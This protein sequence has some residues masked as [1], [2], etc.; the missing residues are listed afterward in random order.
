M[1]DDKIIYIGEALKT[2]RK[3]R[4]LSQEEV[5]LGSE[6][7]RSYI[8]EMERNLKSPSLT[9]IVKLSIVLEVTP[10]YL[11]K[12][13]TENIDFDTFLDSEDETE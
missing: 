3:E 11:V 12:K 8:S 5:A 13:A 7:D 2:I 10:E 1:K 4:G 6:L 9:T